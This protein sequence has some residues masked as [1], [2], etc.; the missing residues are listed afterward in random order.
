M[1]RRD[2]L[3]GF[4]ARVAGLRGR[5]KL[6]A[7]A[8]EVFTAF[9]AAG[10]DALLL[11]GPALALALYTEGETRA[12]ADIDVLVAPGD[13]RRARA[14]LA[15]A[16][17]VDVSDKLGIDD[18]AGVVHDETW[19]GPDPDGHQMVDLHRRLPGAEAPAERVWAVLAARR[20]S[21]EL[22]GREIPVLR[23]EGLA[24]HVATHAAQHGA[25]HPKGIIDLGLALERWPE[26]VW[27][28][29]AGLAAEIEARAAFATGLRLVPEGEQMAERVGLVPALA[30]EWAL[31]NR[32]DRPRGTF[33]L[34]AFAEAG[35]LR[36]RVGVV[37]RALLPRR[38]W[39]V[40]TYPWAR[41]GGPRL[42]AAYLLH[43]ARAPRWAVRAWR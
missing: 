8:A 20:T 10:V 9:A 7:T 17:Y 13:L 1:E 34:Q 37:R 22:A 39:I 41:H 23:R 27:H 11:K 40:Y 21:I 19:V 30:A 32:A 16:G 4:A 29:A 26:E 35:G 14:A 38:A 5:A 12:Y 36:T 31:A 33:H 25:G 28:G 42:V 6:D 2:A 43:G 24:L 15:E 18:V 3:T